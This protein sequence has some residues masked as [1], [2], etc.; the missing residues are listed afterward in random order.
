MSQSIFQNFLSLIYPNCCAC[1]GRDLFYSEESICMLCE[2]N[3]PKTKFHDIEDNPVEKTLYGRF[4]YHAATA[5]LYF[6][7]KGIVH[8]LLHELKYNDNME[9]GLKVGKLFGDSLL[10]SKRFSSFDYLIP[11]PL[12]PKK[13]RKRGYNQALKIAE[14]LNEAFQTTIAKNILKRTI[15]SPTQTK[16][17]RWQRWENV[18]SIFD[19]NDTKKLENK[20]ILLIDDVITTGA[21][22]EACCQALSK[23]KG[24]EIYIACLAIP[25]N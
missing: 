6:S 24:I 7:K 1:C 9:V 19:I 16:K 20:K 21:T 5:F 10:K 17:N 25:L 8:R 18:S 14:G 11:V 22:I 2:A 3:L 4:Q 15:F 13:E 12:H 23:I